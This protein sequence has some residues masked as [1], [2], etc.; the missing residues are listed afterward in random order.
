MKK[1]A[2]FM[3]IFFFAMICYGQENINEYSSYLECPVPDG[4][5]RINRTTY[6]DEAGNIVLSI[7]NNLVKTCTIGAAFEYT[8][9]ANH[10]LAFYYNYFEDN[11]WEYSDNTGLEIYFYDSVYAIIIRAQKREDGQ[12]VSMVMLTRDLNWL[13]SN[14]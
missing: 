4:F 3:I 6:M 12:I 8:H 7:E 9:E 2:L 11:N 10:W 1:Y 5:H 14:L 13:M